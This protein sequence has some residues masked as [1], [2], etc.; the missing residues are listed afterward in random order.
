MKGSTIREVYKIRVKENKAYLHESREDMINFHK[1]LYNSPAAQEAY[2]YM[3][4]LREAV[5]AKN[6]AKVQELLPRFYEM[7]SRLIQADHL[8]Y[9]TSKEQELIQNAYKI[10]DSP[11]LESSGNLNEKVAENTRFG[12]EISLMNKNV[13]GKELD[14]VI[15]EM[16]D[17]EILKILSSGDSYGLD[18]A[19]YIEE[20][21][22]ER[23]QMIMN[24]KEAMKKV[25]VYTGALVLGG[26]VIKANDEEPDFSRILINE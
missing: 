23:K 21:P 11:R 1:G 3:K 24:I 5:D 14:K 12:S 25:G 4:S 16:S 20:N 2:Q 18:Y 10:P 22:I 15:D 17:E 13:A 7:E 9:L 6:E 8:P 19:K 26:Q